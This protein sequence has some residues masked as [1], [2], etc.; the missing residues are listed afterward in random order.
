MQLCWVSP[1]TAWGLR[2]VII[3]G[4]VGG[5]RQGPR[6]LWASQAQRNVTVLEE[7]QGLVLN[8]HFNETHREVK[9]KGAE[10]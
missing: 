1:L 3:S 10:L 7:E 2:E 6:E 4:S 5:K 9:A 8:K